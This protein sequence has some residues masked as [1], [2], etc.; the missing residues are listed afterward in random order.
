MK[1]NTSA[2]AKVKGPPGP[3]NLNA[4]P[5]WAGVLPLLL[6]YVKDKKPSVQFTGHAE[7]TRMA[8]CADLYNEVAQHLL[9]G[10][11]CGI[12]DDAPTYRRQTEKLLA[13]LRKQRAT[14]G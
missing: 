13:R 2:N 5:T 10:F 9:D 6:A 4:T 3:K 8:A 7:L 12:F 11:G 1:R 14:I